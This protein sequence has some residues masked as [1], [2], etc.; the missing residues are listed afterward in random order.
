MKNFFPILL[1]L[2]LFTVLL[3]GCVSTPSTPESKS[4]EEL[5]QEQE[6]ALTKED[7]I[8]M[9]QEVIKL[10]QRIFDDTQIKMDNSQATLMDLADAKQKLADAK[11]KLDQLQNRQDMVIQELQNLVQFYVNTR[12]QMVEQLDTG[13][14]KAKD[15]Y[16]LEIALME[17]NIRLSEAV[18]KIKQQ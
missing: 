9:Y 7:I 6:E 5:K 16:E 4:A 1:I 13:K 18:L 17:A 2:F 10:R 11:I 15:L 12:G 8:K 14:G 3:T